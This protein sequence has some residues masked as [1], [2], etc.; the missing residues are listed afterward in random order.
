MNNSKEFICQSCGMPLIDFADFGTDADGN[1]VN[2]YCAYCFQKGA[3]VDPDITLEQKIDQ[4]VAAAKINMFLSE[5]D[6]RAMAN[7]VIPMLRRWK[8]DPLS[9]A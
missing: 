4:V 8:K 7:E 1:K 5:K 3:F 6:A 9:P 2:D